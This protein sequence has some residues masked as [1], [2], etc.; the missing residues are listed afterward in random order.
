L[1]SNLVDSE[2]NIENHVFPYVLSQLS[3]N[4]YEA[5][6]K[7]FLNKKARVEKYNQEMDAY[8]REFPER[9]KIIIEKIEAHK[10]NFS[11][12]WKF[13]KELME[14]KYQKT[15]NLNL[16]NEREVIDDNNLKEFEISNLVRLGL[17]RTIMKHCVYANPIQLPTKREMEY[18]E[19]SEL[20]VN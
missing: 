2:Q 9:E 11:N 17:A 7:S 6:E 8:E 15:R 3:L 20:D 1:I 14:L 18:G 19:I 4:E 12:K 10:D 5:L 16:I 13:E